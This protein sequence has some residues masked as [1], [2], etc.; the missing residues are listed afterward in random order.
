MFQAI[1]EKLLNIEHFFA[2]ENSF[3]SKLKINGELGH[4]LGIVGKLLMSGI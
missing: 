2:I 1:V 4:I 3:K